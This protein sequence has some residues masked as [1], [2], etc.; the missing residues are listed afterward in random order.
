[1]WTSNRS[2]PYRPRPLR[3]KEAIT[4]SHWF[5]NQ[6]GQRKGVVHANASS[7]ELSANTTPPLSLNP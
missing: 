4:E 3:R 5:R 1:M 2:G 6:L 7:A